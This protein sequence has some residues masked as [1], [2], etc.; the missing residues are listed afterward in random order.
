MIDNHDLRISNVDST[1]GRSMKLPVCSMLL[2]AARS[3]G[4]WPGP[5]IHMALPSFR[6][7]PFLCVVAYSF[8]KQPVS[9]P[10]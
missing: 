1:P 2:P 8:I 5:R 3:Q 9:L 6:W 7:V 4:V 10:L